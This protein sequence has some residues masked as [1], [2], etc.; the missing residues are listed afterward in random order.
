MRLLRSVEVATPLIVVVRMAPLVEIALPVMTDVVAVTPLMVVERVL[1]VTDCVKELIIVARV[2]DTPLTIVWRKLAE[3]DAV[4]DVMTEVVPTDPPMF[5]E[6][7]LV[8]T[9]RVLEVERLVMVAVTALNIVAK[10][11]DD[12]VVASVVDPE[13]VLLPANV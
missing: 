13:N 8:A 9:E 4:L 2:E 5:E 1:P 3:E 6:S 10:R 7:V 12:V 11:F